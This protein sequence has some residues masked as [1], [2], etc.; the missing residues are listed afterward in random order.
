MSLVPPKRLFHVPSMKTVMTLP[1]RPINAIV[2]VFFK[3][4]VYTI[5][6]PSIDGSNSVHIFVVFLL[7]V[8]MV[9]SKKNFVVF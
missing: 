4:S 5:T 6:F 3:K 7:H 2:H 1:L 9:S 8:S